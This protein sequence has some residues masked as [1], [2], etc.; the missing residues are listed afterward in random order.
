[1]SGRISTTLFRG[2]AVLLLGLLLQ[3]CSP[4]TLGQRAL[5][6]R[7]VADITA[8]TELFARV[9]AAMANNKTISVS[10]LVYEQVV[11]LYGLIDDKRIMDAL[12]AD[13]R[14]I[15]GIETLHWHVTYM[16]E[17]DQA[18][19]DDQLLGLTGT[20]KAQG[21]IEAGWLSGDAINSLNFRVGIDDLGVAYLIGRAKSR[22]ERNGVLAVVQGTKGIRKIVDYTKIIP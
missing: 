2:F 22:A 3:A 10:S 1:M 20:T 14:E 16:S 18:A 12:H 9:T 4:V 11:V 7:S 17:A 6:D 13:I 8:D 21:A 19:R 15:D 5:E